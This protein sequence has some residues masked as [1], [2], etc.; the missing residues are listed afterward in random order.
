MARRITEDYDWTVTA[1][2]L[3]EINDVAI[4]M[5][6]V[7]SM[8]DVVTIERFKGIAAA[9]GAFVLLDVRGKE[10]FGR[11]HICG[12][13]NVQLVDIERDAPGLIPAEDARVIVCG[14]GVKDAL[15]AVAA[16]K[17]FTLGYENVSR[18]ECTVDEWVKEGGSVERVVETPGE[19][20]S[21]PS[22][23]GMKNAA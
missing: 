11:A 5:G 16:D 21:A 23:G 2:D 22:G 10:E 15:S 17:L 1:N 3:N 4:F 13:L 12:A 20:A 8:Y 18:L 6:P 7:T 19:G 9:S 14:L